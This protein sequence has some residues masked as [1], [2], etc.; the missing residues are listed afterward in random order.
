VEISAPMLDKA[1]F[2]YETTAETEARASDCAEV[3]LRRVMSGMVVLSCILR[4]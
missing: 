4:W 2:S 3:K 1:E